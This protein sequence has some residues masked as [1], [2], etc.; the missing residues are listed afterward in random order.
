[1]KTYT[2]NERGEKVERRRQYI[3]AK[4]RYL[5]AHPFCEQCFTAPATQLHHSHGRLGALLTYERF[6][7]EIGGADLR[8]R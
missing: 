3:K 5:K 8:F 4:H 2:T 1:V 7:G 6:M